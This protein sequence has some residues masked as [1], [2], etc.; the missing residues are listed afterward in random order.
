MSEP[1]LKPAEIAGLR[2]VREAGA[3]GLVLYPREGFFCSGRHLGMTV[4]RVLAG[5][6][7]VNVTAGQIVISQDGLE[8]LDGVP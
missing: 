5:H 7:L 3:R 1:H 2:E 6:G 8:L 4:F